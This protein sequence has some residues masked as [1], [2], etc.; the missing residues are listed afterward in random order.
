MKHNLAIGV[1]EA[2]CTVLCDDV[3]WKI[4][5]IIRKDEFEVFK[6]EL[7]DTTYKFVVRKCDYYEDLEPFDQTQTDI[8]S[9]MDP[10]WQWINYREVCYPNELGCKCCVGAYPSVFC[11]KEWCKHQ[12]CICKPTEGQYC[13]CNSPYRRQYQT[14]QNERDPEQPDYEYFQNQLV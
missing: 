9:S 5:E 4:Q 1:K 3:A 12:E 2:L 14:S 8:P 10:Y 11:K 7:I 13:D 6:Q